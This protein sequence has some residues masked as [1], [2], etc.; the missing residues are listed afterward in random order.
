MTIEFG[1]PRGEED[2]TS[3]GS[4]L[5]WAFGFDPTD[6]RTWLDHGGLVNVRIARRGDRVVGGLLEIP[7]GQWFGGRSVPML[8]VAGVGV[9]PEARGEGTAL[10]LVLDALRAAR[11]RGI[12]LSTLYPATVTLY[13]AAGFE[14]AGS[15][16]RLTAALG[17]LPTVRGDLDVSPLEPADAPAVEALYRR[18]A[19]ERPGYLDR[20]PYVWQRARASRKETYRGFVVRG[21][22]GLEGYT[23]LSQRGPDDQRELVVHDLV[24]TTSGALRRFMAFFADHRSTVKWLTL[25]ASAID[26][27]VF[28]A[29]ERIFRIE[30][31]EQW[32]LRIL[33]VEGALVARGYPLIDTTVDFELSDRTLPENSGRYR[34]EVS[35]GRA[36]VTAGGTG[37]VALDERALAALYS[38]FLSP[39]A[40]VS[41]GRLEGEPLALKRLALLFAGPPPVMPDYF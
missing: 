13:R 20:G 32:M 38:G 11:Q 14:L 40:L 28:C 25:R 33:D 35:A 19:G 29:P 34:L 7:M 4:I 6:A 31:S 39:A 36:R 41:A 18:I 30:L 22:G 5:G 16:Y 15:R 26:P 24:T 1:S 12:F 37:A 9:A 3:L 8:G 27:I 21:A 17:D 2:L 10:A 23:Y